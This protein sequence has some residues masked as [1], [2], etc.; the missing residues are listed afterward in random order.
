MG[1]R[2]RLGREQAA[3]VRALLAGGAVPA[4]FDPERVRIEARALHAKRRGIAERLRPDLVEA[5][6]ERFGPLFDEWAAD[7]PRRSGVSFRAD[8][9]EFAAWLTETGHLRRPKRRWWTRFAT[10]R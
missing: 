7:R 9:E 4:G 6:G 8:L 2:E 1:E 5:L 3:L 10:D